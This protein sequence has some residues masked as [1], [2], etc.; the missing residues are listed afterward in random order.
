[1][2]AR[3]ELEGGMF[4]YGGD[5]PANMPHQGM[6]GVSLTLNYDSVGKAEQVFNA[7]A[8]GGNVTMPFSDTFWAKKFGMVTDKFGCNW[9]VNGE[10]IDLEL[11][12]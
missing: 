4:L 11:K 12:G 5:C 6:H 8:K 1:M 10:L 9:I 7:L 3:L 2:H